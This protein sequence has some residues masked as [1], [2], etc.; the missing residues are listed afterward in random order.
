MGKILRWLT[1][2]PALEEAKKLYDVLAGYSIFNGL[3]KTQ[4]QN[5]VPALRHKK[6]QDEEI[7]CHCPDAWHDAFLLLKGTVAVTHR[8]GDFLFV[9]HM[10][11]TGDIFNIGPLVGLKG[12]SPGVKALGTVEIL[13]IDNT[14]LQ[15]KLGAEPKLGYWFIL[16][17]CRLAIN[18][19][20]Q[21]IEHYIRTK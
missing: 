5:M 1:K 10:G 17:I 19:Y 8:H 11:K 20:E 4:L 16:N 12:E 3:D 9:V 13:A 15:K 6:F 21:Q 2:E 14:K 18:Q 7:V